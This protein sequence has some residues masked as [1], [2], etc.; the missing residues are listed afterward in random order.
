MI[1]TKIAAVAAETI[2]KADSVNQVSR[3]K[4][5]GKRK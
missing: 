5:F 2:P 3:R 4:L 1:D